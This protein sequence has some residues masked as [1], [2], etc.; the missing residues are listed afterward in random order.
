VPG[1][2][3]PCSTRSTSPAARL[4]P[5]RRSGPDGAELAL[6]DRM[7]EATAAPDPDLGELRRLYAEQ[8]RLRVPS[9]VVSYSPLSGEPREVALRP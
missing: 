3:E 2:T 4:G 6:L 8:P 1:P 7:A 9:R 5:G